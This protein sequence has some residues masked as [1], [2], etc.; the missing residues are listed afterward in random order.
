MLKQQ[1]KKSVKNTCLP[2]RRLEASFRI[3]PPDLRGVLD[4]GP[5][6][7][8]MED[9]ELACF[10][11]SLYLAFIAFIRYVI[12]ICFFYFQDYFNAR[13]QNPYARNVH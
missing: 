4:R 7:Q 13:N 3:S 2:V 8:E 5:K 11:W 9:T 1:Q 6:S 12:L 10:C